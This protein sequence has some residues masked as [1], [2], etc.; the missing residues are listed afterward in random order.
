[1]DPFLTLYGPFLIAP[2]QQDKKK[3]KRDL[4]EI[5]KGISSL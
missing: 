2:L 1:M 3:E 4:D 5:F